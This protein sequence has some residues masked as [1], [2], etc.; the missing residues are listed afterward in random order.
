MAN[1]PPPLKREYKEVVGG[2][3][4]PTPFKKEN[5]KKWKEVANR[6]PPLKKPEKKE[7][8]GG[9]KPPTPFKKENT[10]NWSEV[11]NRKPSRNLHIISKTLRNTMAQK[12]TKTN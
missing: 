12:S 4:P 1:R 11:A 7:V 6:P 2:G 10:K 9:G 8:V 5:T 3:K